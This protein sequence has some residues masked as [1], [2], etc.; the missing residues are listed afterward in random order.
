MKTNL[1][2]ERYSQAGPISPCVLV[3]SI[4]SEGRP[5]I[6]TLGMYMPIS[7]DPQQVVIGVSPKRYSHDLIMEQGEFVVNAPGIGMAEKMHICGIKSGRD[8]DKFKEAGLTAK[9]AQRVRP[10]LIEEC[11]GH[12]ECEV[13]NMVTCGD[14]TLFVGEVVAASIDEDCLEGGKLKLSAARPIAQKNWD[15]HTL[16]DI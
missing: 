10:P 11:Y 15:Y 1:P 16:S 12:L 8:V 7:H 6:I 14:H 13:V 4:D 3:T 9:P 2:K 5:N